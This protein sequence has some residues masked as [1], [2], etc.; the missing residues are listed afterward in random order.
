MP[1]TRLTG[2]YRE[3]LRHCPA[4]ALR[5]VRVVDGHLAEHLRCH[6]VIEQVSTWSAARARWIHPE[7]AGLLG[8][9]A[10]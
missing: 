8:G 5:H 9:R 7:L 1:A 6:D 4:Q 10:T 3:M 2:P